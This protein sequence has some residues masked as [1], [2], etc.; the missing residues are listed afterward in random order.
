MNQIRLMKSYISFEDVEAEFRQVFETGIFTRGPFIQQF[1][2]KLCEFS[3]ARY[4]FPATSATTALW[5]CMRVLNLGPGDEV[6]VSDFSFPATANVVEDLGATPVFADVDIKTFNMLPEALEAAISSKTKAVVF[7][8]ALGNP[9]GISKIKAICEKHDLPLIEDAACAIGSSEN[10]LRCGSIADMTCYS[11]HPRKLI[12]TGEGGAIT[13]NRE[14]WAEW[15]EVKLFHG[16]KGMKGVALDFVDYGFNF[17]LPELQAI[18]GMKQLDRIEEIIR[19]RNEIR[20]QYIKALEPLGFTPQQIGENVVYNVQSMV[21]TVPAGLNR[22]ALIAK[23]K[24]LGVETTIGTYAMSSGTYFERKYDN[25]QPNSNW[26][27]NNTITLPCYEQVDVAAVCT[28]IAKS[29]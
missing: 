28:A 18:M 22:D 12:S 2:D 26:L 5:T 21:F 24:E 16:A 8:D 6:I 14:D 1:K 17:R 20:D 27:Q 9:T 4:A 10:G 19:H 7:V 3:G 25:V 23:L 29:V 15:L 13:T 11:F